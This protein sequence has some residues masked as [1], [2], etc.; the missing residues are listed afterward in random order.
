MTIKEL[1]QKSTPELVS[2]IEEKREELRKLR[3]GTTGSGMRNTHALRTL[4]KEI[5]RGLTL[6][7]M[8][9]KETA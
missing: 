1:Q 7:R 2:Y 6:L 8:G 3:F 5:A 9:A 4:R